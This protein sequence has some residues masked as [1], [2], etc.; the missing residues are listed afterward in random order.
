MTVIVAAVVKT[1]QQGIIIIMSRAHRKKKVG[2]CL[3]SYNFMLE[4]FR[5]RINAMFFRLN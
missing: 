2:I 3:A 5:T 4:H 1:I